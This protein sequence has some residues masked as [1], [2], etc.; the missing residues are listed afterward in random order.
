M[1]LDGS[2]KMCG[3]CNHWGGKRECVNGLVQ[4]KSSAR[5]QCAILNKPKPPHGGCG[6]WEKWDGCKS[7]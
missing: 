3:I 4:V 6:E 2:K 7:Q 5:G 1:N